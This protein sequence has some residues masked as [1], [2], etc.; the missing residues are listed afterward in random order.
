MREHPRSAPI[1]RSGTSRTATTTPTTSS[2][3]AC[4]ADARR[5]AGVELLHRPHDRQQLVLVPDVPVRA[6][7]ASTFPRGTSMP[8]HTFVRSRELWLGKTVVQL[9][10]F[11]DSTTVAGESVDVT[12]AWFPQAKVLHVADVIWPGSHTFFADGTSVPDWFIQLEHVRDLVNELKP[13]VIVP[14]HGAPGDAG[15]ID[16]QERYLSD[17]LAD[18]PGLLPGRRG[19]AH[20]RGE[21]EA[22]PGDRQRLPRAPEPHPARH[23]PA[24]AADARPGGVPR[25][26]ARRRDRAPLPTFL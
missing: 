9:F 2:A 3:T 10:E 26:P 15:M 20:R 1:S 4:S 14:G 11:T 21:G 13:R 5:R 22:P 8:Q 12:M 24:A 19:R 23:Q 18:R 25:R 17:G 6:S 16:A 7:G